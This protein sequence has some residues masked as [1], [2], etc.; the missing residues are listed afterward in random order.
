MLRG[1]KGIAIYPSRALS[2]HCRYV[3][4]I[5]DTGGRKRKLTWDLGGENLA[6][7]AQYLSKTGEIGSTAGLGDAELQKV[8]WD[9]TKTQ[10]DAIIDN[11]H[12]MSDN[13][14]QVVSSML[15]KDDDLVTRSVYY[16]VA[17]RCGFD[18]SLE[19]FS[20]IEAINKEDVIYEL[21][22]FVSDI[23]CEVLRG[24]GQTLRQMKYTLCQRFRSL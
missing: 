22:S 18:L 23:S 4:D 6:N 9:F 1:S 20:G 12:S 17:S 3:F 16:V 8:I 7:Y 24:I 11:N 21:G 14:K 5:S 19:D 15:E 13:I 2:S 10:I